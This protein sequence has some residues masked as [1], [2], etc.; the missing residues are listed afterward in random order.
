LTALQT[1]A[2]DADTTPNVCDHVLSG[3]LPPGQPCNLARRFSFISEC[4]V[5]T[6]CVAGPSAGCQGV[7][8]AGGLLTKPCDFTR[9]CVSGETCNL[10]TGTCDLKGS[11][12]DACGIDSIIACEAG[13]ACSDILSGGTC[14]IR[15]AAGATCS[16]PFECAFGTACDRGLDIEGTCRVPPKPGD[17]CTPQE[18]QCTVGLSYCGADSKCHALAGLG[19]PCVST[20]GEG[21]GCAVGLCDTTLATPVCKAA[22]VGGYCVSDIDCGPNALCVAQ[23][24]TAAC[25]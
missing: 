9:P 5:G 17:A 19:Q 4:Q 2:C 24:C 15:K 23:T 22:A 10:G 12:G 8:V 18:Y 25:F 13:L 16:T 20:D 7:C 11:A 3:Q 1:L 21:T 6:F 14:T